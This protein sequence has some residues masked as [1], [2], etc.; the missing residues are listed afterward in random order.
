MVTLL[1]NFLH[2]LILSI[3]SRWFAKRFL[4]PDIVAAYDYIFI[5]DEDLE[6]EHFNAEE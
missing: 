4:H 6:L 3:H 2:V 1:T 5:W